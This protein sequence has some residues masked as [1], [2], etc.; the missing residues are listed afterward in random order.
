MLLHHAITQK[1]AAVNCLVNKEINLSHASFYIKNLKLVHN[2]L[3]QNKYPR[4][5]VEKYIDKRLTILDNIL[6]CASVYK[7]KPN[8]SK[9]FLRILA[10][11]LLQLEK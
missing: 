1:I 2:L 4:K 7:Y 8:F 6:P 10:N 9:A 11:F 5:F 3:M